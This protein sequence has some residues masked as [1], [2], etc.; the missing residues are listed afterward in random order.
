MFE[1]SGKQRLKKNW[2]KRE[3]RVVR[4]RE[5]EMREKHECEGTPEM[6]IK[7]KSFDIGLP[8]LPDEMET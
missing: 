5:N 3:E 8:S 2:K 7:E 6:I 1:R 4:K